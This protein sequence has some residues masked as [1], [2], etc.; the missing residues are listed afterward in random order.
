MNQTKLPSWRPGPTRDALEVFLD[1]AEML[2][3]EQRVAVFDNDG[4]LWCEKPQYSQVEFYLAELRAALADRP[5]LGDRPEYRALLEGDR[6]AIGQLGPMNVLLA[7]TELHVGMT[8]EDFMGRVRDF[9]ALARHRGR[10]V[11]LSQMRYRP[12]LELIAELRARH[13]S[14]YLVTGSGTEFMRAVSESFYGVPPEGVVGSQVGYELDR[15]SGTPRLVRTRELFG[16]PNE[17]AAKISNI[18]RVLGRRPILAA[19]NSAGDA[20]MLEYA[21]AFDG[22]SLS[23]LVDHDDAEREYAYES[24]A[25]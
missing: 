22:P 14:V 23:L 13:F 9:F 16:D 18:Q 21:A 11:P 15:S 5:E 24:V 19:G 4:T 17:G 7:L 8:P 25:G 10:A 20:D 6:K 3:I 12:M 2:P 1:A